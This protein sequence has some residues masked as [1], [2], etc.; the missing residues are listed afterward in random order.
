[1]AGGGPELAEISARKQLIARNDVVYLHG[2]S[3]C[4]GP[5]YDAMGRPSH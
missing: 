2:Y 4:I 1:M 3:H 5:V